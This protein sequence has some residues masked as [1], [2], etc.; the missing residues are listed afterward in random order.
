MVNHCDNYS[1]SLDLK[2]G[3]KHK[4]FLGMVRFI[5][6]LLS[7]YVIFA[8]IFRSVDNIKFLFFICCYLLISSLVI[9]Y[10]RRR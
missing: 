4:T 1:I 8:L 2:M 6:I 10:L 7:F 3:D 5:A 9:D